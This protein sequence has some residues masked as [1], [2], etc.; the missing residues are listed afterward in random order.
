MER[1][2]TAVAVGKLVL[3]LYWPEFMGRRRNFQPPAASYFRPLSQS[4][5][6]CKINVKRL[7]QRK[8]SRGKAV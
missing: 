8:G 2:H 7:S 4:P 6:I 3:L 1:V 5:C